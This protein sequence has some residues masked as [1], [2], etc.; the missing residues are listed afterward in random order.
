MQRNAPLNPPA[1]KT[2][3]KAKASF[4]FSSLFIERI[5]F[6]LPN[7]RWRIRLSSGWRTS[8]RHDIGGR[9]RRRPGQAPQMQW[10]PR[11]EETA[12]ARR[13]RSRPFSRN[14]M[15]P[16]FAYRNQT[17]LRREPV[18]WHSRRNEEDDLHRFVSCVLPRGH[19]RQKLF[20]FLPGAKS[21]HFDERAT[22]AGDG[23]DFS[24]RA[25]LQIKQVNHKSLR[26]FERFHKM[27]DKLARRKALVG[28]EV[29]GRRREISDHRSLF[30]AQ[31]GLAQF[32]PGFLG[33]DLVDTG[34]DRDPRDP[35][36]QRHL[37]GKLRQVLQNFNEN[38]LAK[39][40]FRAANR[41]MGPHEFG[42]Q[43]IQIPHQLARRGLLL[44]Q[45]RRH[46]LARDSVFSHVKPRQSTPS[47]LTVDCA[48]RLQKFSTNL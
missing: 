10:R 30:F 11:V 16:R 34:I 20:H 5:P 12:K 2:R 47:R 4:H 9:W 7:L 27:L 46:Q 26:W 32:R 38:H 35:M 44:P 40:L 39:V 45:H 22:P 21:A 48:S 23:P 3:R 8:S 19:I 36:L 14:A 42:D 43:R 37:A 31:V 28:R 13:Y 6:G 33:L 18:R 24:D 15:T 41:A 17:A 29:I 25:L 1:T